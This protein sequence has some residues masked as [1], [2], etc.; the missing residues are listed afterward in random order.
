MVTSLILITGSFFVSQKAIQKTADAL[1]QKQI[2]EDVLRTEKLML[3]S[4]EDLCGTTSDWAQW[5]DTY[6][7]IYGKNPRYIEENYLEFFFEKLDIRYVFFLD[8]KGNHINDLFYKSETNE[9]T[10]VPKEQ[11][12]VFDNKYKNNFLKFPV[13]YETVSGIVILDGRPVLM[14]AYQ[15]TNSDISNKS[16]G[17]LIFGR[18]VD[19]HAIARYQEILNLIIEINESSENLKEAQK[20]A[21]KFDIS[22]ENISAIHYLKDISGNQDVRLKITRERA[23]STREQ[24]VL[25]FFW[26]IVAMVM[27]SSALL[28]LLLLKR[29]VTNPIENMGKFINEIDLDKATPNEII[30]Q[31]GQ[32]GASK[33]EISS[34]MKKVSEMVVRIFKDSEKIKANENRIKLALN[35]SK[36]GVW[37][38]RSD[39]KSVFVDRH[40]AQMIGPY[41]EE[42]TIP[43]E[44]LSVYLDSE[45]LGNIQDLF[46]RMS[47][48]QEDSISYECKIKSTFGRHV[49]FVITGDV[50]KRN[51]DGSIKVVSGLV[52]NIDKQK[53]LE[54]ELK[55]ISYHDRLTGLY[56]RRYF[57]KCFLDFE[58]ETF[59]PLTILVGDINGLKLTND[60]F[61]HEE[62]DRLLIST[63]NVLKKVCRKSDIICRWG[64][65]EFVL[66]LPKSDETIA[67]RIYEKIKDECKKEKLGTIDLNIALG[68]STRIALQESMHLV[69]KTAEENMYR[70]KM[71]EADQTRTDIMNTILNTLHDKALETF[72]HYDRMATLGVEIAKN[73]GIH[74][75]KI[76]DIVAISRLHDIGKIGIAE[77]YLKRSG[78]LSE[79]EWETVKKHTDIGYRIVLALQEYAHLAGAVLAHHE[80]YNGEGYPKGLVQEEIPLIARIISVVDAVDI[81]LNGCPYKPPKGTVNAIEELKKMSG[82]QFDPKIVEEAVKILLNQ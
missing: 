69:M 73:L 68:Y 11:Y 50:T 18:V 9:I 15:I 21:V 63:A 22:G 19:E 6:E 74:E 3:G 46:D 39:T 13:E 12:Q 62:G 7:Y 42:R 67:K 47:E 4:L 60:T 53:K 1:D 81:M 70:N 48:A 30:L 57:D 59:L 61:G 33:D 5:D 66:L 14:S 17:V 38:Y 37:E 44:R 8:T 24:S 80:W 72:Q 45:D 28:T 49:W 71:F 29:Y 52:L 23:I 36:A 32:S 54:S 2:E 78:S 79:T 40:L 51:Q 26:V 75:E 34:L 41:D 10:T 20:E 43:L 27:T 77:E 56:N 82:V 55:Y 31:W 35:A 76:N 65:D 16:E 58:E 64:G 25:R